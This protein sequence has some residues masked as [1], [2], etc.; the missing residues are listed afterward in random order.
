M[1]KNNPFKGAAGDVFVFI[2]SFF[3]LYENCCLSSLLPSPGAKMGYPV[4]NPSNLKLALSSMS[5]K[6]LTQKEIKIFLIVV[7]YCD[8]K[9]FDNRLLL[10][11]E[12]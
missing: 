6:N 11:V 3:G 5:K 12:E 2:C 8:N 4:N 10:Y 7:N 1:E 9:K